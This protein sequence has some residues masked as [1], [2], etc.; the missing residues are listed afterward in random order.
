MGWGH[1]DSKLAP[2]NRETFEWFA[3]PRKIYDSPGLKPPQ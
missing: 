3:Q 2:E 1:S